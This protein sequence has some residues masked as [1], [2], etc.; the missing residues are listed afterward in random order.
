[1]AGAVAY[2]G[3]QAR[4]GSTLEAELIHQGADRLHQL[5]VIAFSNASYAL[6]DAELP[7]CC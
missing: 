2:Q 6:T 5:A 3:D 7:A 4:V 1:M